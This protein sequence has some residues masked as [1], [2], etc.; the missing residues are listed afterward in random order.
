[1]LIFGIIIVFYIIISSK[2]TS[3]FGYIIGIPKVL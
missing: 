2:N 3:K 1:M